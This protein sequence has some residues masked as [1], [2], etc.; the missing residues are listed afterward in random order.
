MVIKTYGKRPNKYSARIPR[1]SIYSRTRPHNHQTKK[2]APLSQILRFPERS[3]HAF[4]PTHLSWELFAPADHPA[5]VVVVGHCE[6]ANA[7]HTGLRR[8]QNSAPPRVPG[9]WPRP[10]AAG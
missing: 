5:I 8:A 4:L 7:G 2:T 6:T 10:R 1:L 3:I 9:K